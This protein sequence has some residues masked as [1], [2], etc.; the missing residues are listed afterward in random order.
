[1]A[2]T[3]EQWFGRVKWQK[4]AYFARDLKPLLQ[5]CWNAANPPKKQTRSQQQN[6]YMWGVVY[7][8]I[9]KDTGYTDKEV[10][11][12]MGKE[13]LSYDHL[14][15]TFIRSTTDLNTKGME[16]YLEKVRRFASSEL[17]IYIPLPNEPPID[18]KLGYKGE[19]NK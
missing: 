1:M 3:F 19:K 9:S 15:E 14:G 16:E 10:H 4:S 18:E 2:Q 8:I 11:A 13:F 17:S 6:A 7:D 5:M 12:L